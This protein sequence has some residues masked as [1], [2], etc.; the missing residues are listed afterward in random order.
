[1]AGRAKKAVGNGRT[2][3]K[4]GRAVTYCVVPRELAGKLHESLR[5]HFREDPGVEVVVEQRVGERRAGGERRWRKLAAPDAGERRKVRSPDGVRVAQRRSSVVVSPRELPRKA[6]PYAERLAFV[7]RLRPPSERSEDIDTARLVTLIQGGDSE[8][9]GELYMRYFDRVYGYFCVVV[10]DTHTAED[11]AQEVFTKVLKA[12]PRY[13]HRSGKLFRAWLFIIVRNEAVNEV[14]RR[15]RGQVTDPT[16]LDSLREEI[17]PD[18]AQ[19]PGFDWMAD[20]E[21]N[22]F[23]ERLPLAQRQVLV[24]RHMIGF[25]YPEI[26]SIL[27]RNLA[28]VR[29]LNSRGRRGRC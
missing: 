27:G 22:M 12:L 29:S 7:A 26:A 25:S 8:A 21:L 15:G 14:Q 17:E 19:L 5:K 18:G 6:R 24:M 13:E 2:S 23:V 20:R 1:M 4:R 3:E 28:D 10:H 16:E 9:F 11:L